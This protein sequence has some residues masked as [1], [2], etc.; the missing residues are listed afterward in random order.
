MFRSG[1]AGQKDGKEGKSMIHSGFGDTLIGAAYLSVDVTG[2]WE[3]GYSVTL[4][5]NGG[6]IRKLSN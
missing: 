1:N 2:S 5:D 3:D 6:S 4:N